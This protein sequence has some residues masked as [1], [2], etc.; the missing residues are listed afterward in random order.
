MQFTLSNIEL[1][2]KRSAKGTALTNSGLEGHFRIMDNGH[3]LPS[4]LTNTLTIDALTFRWGPLRPPWLLPH[5]KLCL[6][7]F[8][9]FS[10]F[11][12]GYHIM[13]QVAEGNIYDENF[14]QNVYFELLTRQG[15]TSLFCFSLISTANAS[16]YHIYPVTHKRIPNASDQQAPDWLLLRGQRSYVTTLTTFYATSVSVQSDRTCISHGSTQIPRLA[17]SSSTLIRILVLLLHGVR[18]GVGTWQK[19]FYHPWGPAI[20]IKRS[21]GMKTN[22]N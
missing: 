11:I 8:L 13:V 22:A 10:I 14:W 19:V 16:Q 3:I 2:N 21:N 4:L 1:R 7:T 18:H 6:R 15:S 9:I 20:T 12:V 5:L 17:S